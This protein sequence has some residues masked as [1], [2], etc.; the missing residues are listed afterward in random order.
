MV[1][2][3]FGRAIRD[4]HCGDRAH[5]L[6]DREGSE[7]REHPIARFYFGEVTESTPDIRWVESWLAG[8]VVELGAGAG[9]HALYLQ[10]SFDTVATEVSRNLLE[11]MADRGVE[12]PRHVDMF[13]LRSTFG[14]DRFRSVFARGTQVCLAGSPARLRRFLADLAAVTTP[15]ATAVIDGYD[16]GHERASGLFGYRPD[17]V[18]G[19]ARRVYHET[20]ED[21]VGDTLSFW[22]VGPERL[23]AA[24]EDAGWYL[25]EVRSGSVR[26][27]HYQAA[28]TKTRD[29]A[30]DGVGGRE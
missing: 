9:R 4:H 30:P 25:A 8:P 17:P 19:V 16:P 18:R 3:P 13:S 2:D 5:P 7:T 21:E 28:M 26:T 6:V 12:D 20:Y 24:A 22:L 27:P 1:P 29:G 14:P 11:V 23:A 10:D 15:D